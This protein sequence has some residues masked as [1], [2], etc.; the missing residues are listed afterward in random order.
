MRA[1]GQQLHLLN[2]LIESGIIKPVV[3]RIFTLNSIIDAFTYVE[4]GRTKG[5]VVITLN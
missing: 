1:S 4:T 3:D 2:Y 5:K